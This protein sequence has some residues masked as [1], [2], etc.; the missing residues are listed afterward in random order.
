MTR[1]EP[2]VPRRC[3][4]GFWTLAFW[5]LAICAVCLVLA[6]SPAGAQASTSVFERQDA[7]ALTDQ[8][9]YLTDLTGQW[10]PGL[11]LPETG[12]APLTQRWSREN[13]GTRKA[14]LWFRTTLDA[15]R[16]GAGPWLWVVANPH[17]ESV[18]LVVVR[19]G[20]QEMDWRG[21]NA[22]PG[23]TATVREHP[24][25][26]APLELQA[27]GLYTVYMHVRS[28]GI[29]YVPVS[30]WRPSAFWRADQ[31]RYALAGLY[32]GLALGLFAYNLLLYLLI[33]ERVYLYYLGCILLLTLAQLANTGLGAQFFWPSWAASST[34]FHNLAIAGAAVC[35]V[36]FARAFLGT[37]S[38]SPRTDR[39]LLGTL[40][41]WAATACALPWLGSVTAGHVLAPTGIL[42]V[43]LLMLSTLQAISAGRPGARYFALAWATLLVAGALFAL[44]RLGWLPYSPVLADVMMLGSAVE[45]VLLSF[46]LADRIRSERLAKELAIAGGT[47]ETVR[48]EEAQRALREKSRFMAALAH[49]IQ[50]PLYALGLAT[51]SMARHPASSGLA[52]PLAQ[53]QSAMHSVDELLASLVMAVKLDSADLRPAISNHSVQTMLE[54]IDILFTPLAQQRGLDWRVTPCLARIESDPALL[55]RMVCNLVANALRYTEQGGVMLSSRVRRSGLLLQ[56]WDTGPGIEVHEQQSVFDEHFRG[57]A[58]RAG[59]CGMGLGLSIVRRCALLLGIRV[60]LRSVAGRGSCFELL[61]PL[62]ADPE[63]AAAREDRLR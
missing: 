1:Q 13:F 41:A 60:G 51:E 21:G 14:D 7:I 31:M 40:V 22:A 32:F 58:G 25:H 9:E 62:S 44:H 42:T 39:W 27:A 24:F 52:A 59:D 10:Q 36:L 29:A 8:L 53:M 35:A 3:R 33:R 16:V 17:L 55:E 20:K 28:Q 34:F 48:R 43:V 63:G 56:V 18:R 26:I 46:A 50:Q 37:R 38:Q 6:P 15:S 19:N 5:T 54:R 11:P 61:V 2:R 49:D 30:L 4:G 47:A 23:R 45:L 12:F 57:A